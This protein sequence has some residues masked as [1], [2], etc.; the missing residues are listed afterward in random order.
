M[1]SQVEILV[2][3]LDCGILKS[4]RTRG[5][6]SHATVLAEIDRDT[7]D[8]V[9][10]VTQPVPFKNVGP[11]RRLLSSH[12]PLLALR[13][14]MNYVFAGFVTDVCHQCCFKMRLSYERPLIVDRCVSSFL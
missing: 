11:Q 5:L 13:G 6:H 9:N 8:T 3:T 14:D 10:E 2:F 4:T 12:S 1:G 7:S